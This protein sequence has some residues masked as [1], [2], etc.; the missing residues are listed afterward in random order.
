L[1]GATPPG[2]DK[3][4]RKANLK[5][6]VGLAFCIVLLLCHGEDLED[7]VGVVHIHSSVS[8]TRRFP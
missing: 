6:F 3:S 2:A 1:P 7:A 8:Y 5:S 4:G